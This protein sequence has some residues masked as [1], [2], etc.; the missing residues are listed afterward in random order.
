[1][2]AVS[3]VIP[4]YNRAQLLPRALESALSQAEVLEVLVVD[5]ASADHPEEAVRL[6]GD[7]RVRCIR[8]ERNQGPAAARNRGVR[9]AK[10]EFVAFLDSDDAWRPG[11]LAA[12]LRF[13]R[14]QGADAV[15]SAFQRHH[16]GEEAE[17]IFP[18]PEVKPGRVRYTDLLFENLVGC[19]TLL[20]RRD[21][22]PAFDESLRALED[23]ELAL[24]LARDHCLVYDGVCRLDVYLQ[25][26]SVSTDSPAL[27]AAAHALYLRHCADINREPRLWRQWIMSFRAWGGEGPLLT[28]EVAAHLPDALRR[29][30]DPEAAIRRMWDREHHPTLLHRIRRKL[31]PE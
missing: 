21:V 16:A 7:A 23:W 24:T 6:A 9:E 2:S 15:F 13:L 11:K 31:M 12:Q 19:P 28:P 8:Q 14:E 29:E 17:D 27:L 22:L 3:V 1:M 10:G 20:A 4:V 25:P 18:R 26:A 5:D 30:P